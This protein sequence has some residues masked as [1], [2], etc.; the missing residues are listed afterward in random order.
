MLISDSSSSQNDQRL[1]RLAAEE[2]ARVDRG[3]QEAALREGAVRQAGEA[4]Q[5][6][7]VDR[8]RALMQNRGETTRA[9]SREPAG[10]DPRTAAKR[11]NGGMPVPTALPADEQSVAERF[12]AAMLRAFDTPRQ[13]VAQAPS[14]DADA[15][16]AQPLEGRAAE[17]P[18]AERPQQE[19]A[20]HLADAERRAR[21]ADAPLPRAQQ[22]S[23]AAPAPKAAA[24]GKQDGRSESL[25]ET[26]DTQGAPSAQQIAHKAARGD[27]ELVQAVRAARSGEDADDKGGQDAS[28]SPSTGSAS[29]GMVSAEM[30]AQPQLQPQ[31]PAAM[32]VPQAAQAQ[33]G[34]APALSELLQKHVRQMLVT[35][36]RSARGRP[37]EVLLRMQNDAL[38]GTDLWLTRTD[39]GWRLRADVSSRDAYDTLLEFQ[40]E[41]VKRFAESRL[42][43]LSIEPVFHGPADLAGPAAGPAMLRPRQG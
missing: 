10:Q 24:D 43:E 2:R 25:R 30:L 21:P 7:D 20:P 12:R 16:A 4:P 17:E 40:D 39:D 29:P 9:A 33:A 27:A 19:A 18:K 22:P 34:F 42:G 1:R 15:P 6:E 3:S 23:D 28:S 37:R 8:F 13:P 36:P 32:D 5:P 35:D 11:E 26:K 41:L 38:P 31:A 14:K